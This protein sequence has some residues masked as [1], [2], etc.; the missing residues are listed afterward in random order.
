MTCKKEYAFEIMA[1][2][3]GPLCNLNCTYC[4]YHYK[5]NRSDP[6]YNWKMDDETLEI[7][8]R[9]YIQSQHRGY[10]VQFVWQG[11][12]PTL[13]GLD[14]FRKAVELQKKHKR[15]DQE[16]TN[17][18]QTNAT[19]I[20]S[21][22]AA[23]FK[24]NN[25][26]VGV[27]IDGPEDIHDHYRVDSAGKGS[28]DRVMNGLEI[29]RNHSVDFNALVCITDISTQAPLDVYDF[30]KKHF[31][32]IQFIPV[33]NEKEFKKEAPFQQYPGKWSRIKG[34]KYSDSVTKWSVTP[35]G[36]GNFLNVIF[37]N[38]VRN[39]VGKVFV[40]L[41]DYTLAN[42]MNYPVALCV[43]N[44]TCGRA[45]VLEHNGTLYACD[46]FVYPEYRL[47][48]IKEISLS[49]LARSPSQIGF[50]DDKWERLPGKCRVCEY[51]NLC[52][53][54]CPKNRFAVTE[55]GESGLNYLCD[56]YRSFF[57][58]TSKAMKFM[59]HE[60]INHR[61]AHTVMKTPLK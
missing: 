18:F 14:F 11:G 38:W 21:E 31:D 58:H 20:D 53:G 23:F 41:F 48:N 17:A 36:L 55:D 42:W 61:P 28:F 59:A 33:V 1:K 24:K 51:F 10:P 9:D 56:G 57:S 37:D 7:F 25:F 50:G 5:K 46:H 49:E 26:L 40:Q 4:F 13:L 2:P 30:L 22:W 52:F 39:D 54:G 45:L 27:S 44:R 47:G 16:I 3:C 34:K 29:L 60:L 32:F 35:E 43:F 15:P 19:L 6:S 12:E 8:V